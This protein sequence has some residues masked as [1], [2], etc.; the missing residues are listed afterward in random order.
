MTFTIKY[1]IRTKNIDITQK[2][3]ATCVKNNIL[4]IPKCG[5]TRNILF[6]D[7]IPNIKKF[8]LVEINNNIYE[9]DSTHNV[10]IDIPDNRIYTD[11]VMSIF[12]I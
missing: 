6:T 1:G 12:N 4:C 9:Y 11:F 3:L 2:A 7:P 8:I 5:N 10:Y